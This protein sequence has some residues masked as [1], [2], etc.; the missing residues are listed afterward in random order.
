[1]N[2]HSALSQPPSESKD[3][4]VD[5]GHS[6]KLGPNDAARNARVQILLGFPTKILKEI[7]GTTS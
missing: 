7:R 5:E 3:A 2:L 4:G 1:M 6:L